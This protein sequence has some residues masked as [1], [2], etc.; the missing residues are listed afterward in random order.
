MKPI[1]LTVSI[2]AAVFLVP[3][4]EAGTIDHFACKRVSGG[5]MKDLQITV[6]YGANM[7]AVAGYQ[8]GLYNPVEP[9]DVTISGASIEWSFMR[10][11]ME[12]DRKSGDLAWDTTAEYEYLQAIG[13]PADDPESDYR[14]VM[15]CRKTAARPSH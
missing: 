2:S 7:V 9:G 13:H 6:D 4:A 1:A 11:Y 3:P 12:L 5:P 15:H 14:G 8:Y 10:G